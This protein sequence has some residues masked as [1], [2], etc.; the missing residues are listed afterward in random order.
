LVDAAAAGSSPIADFEVAGLRFGIRS[1][2]AELSFRMTRALGHLRCEPSSAR[3]LVIDVMTGNEVPLESLGHGFER[4]E[5]VDGPTLVRGRDW[6]A[7]FDP[8]HEIVNLLDR[9]EARALY[10]IGDTGKLPHWEEHFPFRHIHGW[11]LTP[12]GLRLV[13]AGGVGTAGG[14]ALIVGPSG[15]GKSTT[16][17]SCL[18]GRLRTTGDDLALLDLRGPRRALCLYSCVKLE[19]DNVHRFPEW[20]DGGEEVDGKLRFFLNESHRDA[21]ISELPISAVVVPR[22]GEGVTTLQEISLGTALRELAASTVF[23]FHG[24]EGDPLG[25][26]EKVVRDAGCYSLN[27]GSDL[28]SIP[29]LL[30]EVLDAALSRRSAG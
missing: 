27:I 12:Q 14:G 30:E 8:A 3:D 6:E 1:A 2:D 29:G 22:I 20:A 15:R 21:L 28:S 17:L 5:E 9:A 19:H 10:W 7:R 26:F 16:T 24:I 13:H 11:W 25:D 4:I 18:G 23:Q